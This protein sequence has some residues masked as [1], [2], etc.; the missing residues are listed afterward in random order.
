ML[1]RTDGG[2]R[3]IGILR[4]QPGEQLFKNLGFIIIEPDI[5]L[6]INRFKLRMEQAEDGIL[7]AFMFD[8]QPLVG[9]VRRNIVHID[10]LLKRGKGIGSLRPDPGQQFV[11]FVGDGKFRS[12]PRQT[13]DLV[14]NLFPLL[15]IGRLPVNFEFGFNLVEQHLF[16]GKVLGSE[17]IGTLEHHMFQVM[18]QTCV[19]GRIVLTPCPYGNGCL[20]AGCILVYR[21]IHLQPVRQGINPGLEGIA[22]N[23]II[24]IGF[25]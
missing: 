13:V 19:V 5:L 4:E 12:S 2:L 15:G 6:L 20:D 25:L 11:I 7:E 9:L 24:D 3:T 14:I 8:L 18:R 10:R 21:Q 22:L 17:F 23:R 1:D 16:T